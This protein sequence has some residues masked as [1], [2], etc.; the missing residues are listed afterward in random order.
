MFK[1][2]SDEIPDCCFL[3][4]WVAKLIMYNLWNFDLIHL[5]NL[6]L[7]VERK[8]FSNVVRFECCWSLFFLFSLFMVI[9]S[10]VLYLTT[11]CLFMCLK[12]SYILN[13]FSFLMYRFKR[14]RSHKKCFFILYHSF[15]YNHN[16]KE[17]FFQ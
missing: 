17:I 5:F 13:D 2:R 3:E 9:N 15:I 6:F 10:D 11:K 7:T 8:D 4:T 1:L 16:S 12:I 14:R